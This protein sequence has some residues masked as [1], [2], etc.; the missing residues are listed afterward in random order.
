MAANKSAKKNG[1][2]GG[3]GKGQ[4]LDTAGLIETKDS[5]KQAVNYAKKD[6][7]LSM[8]AVNQPSPEI[9]KAVQLQFG[10]RISKQLVSWYNV[11]YPDEIQ[12]I[13]NE[14]IKNVHN[15]VPIANMVNRAL[16]RQKLIDDLQKPTKLWRTVP[17]YYKGRCVGYKLEGSHKV[18]NEILDSQA[19]EMNQI[20]D[21]HVKREMFEIL[22]HSGV[23]AIN[24]ILHKKDGE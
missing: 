8:L 16:I 10:V 12:Q 19:A 5:E 20:E 6:L 23:S 17:V 3:N 11:N 9:I 21:Q 4:A 14:F 2:N 22:K 1:R 18:I 7:I 15:L 24:F 13:R